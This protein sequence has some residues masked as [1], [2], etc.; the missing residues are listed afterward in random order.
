[1]TLTIHDVE[2]RSPEWYAA[3]CGIVTAS[4]IGRLI[5]V[6][7]LGAIDFDC[8]NCGAAANNPCLSKRTSEP[9]KTLHGERT[10]S[11]AQKTTVIEPA[12]N[13]ESRGLIALL[14]AERISGFVDPTWQSIDMWRGIDDEPLAVD[15]YSRTQ[16][17]VQTC[18]F[19][20]NDEFG[21]TIGY[22]PDGL[23]SSDGLI[24]VKAPRGKG[25][26]L[27]VLGDGIPFEHM[28]QIQCGLLV[29]GRSWCDFISYCG[30]MHMYV[31]R[32]RP[33]ERWRKAIIDAARHAEAA[34]TQNIATYME[35][36]EGFPMT[37]R[38][39]PELEMRVA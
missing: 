27:T 11:A 12:N 18:G 9:I 36:V 6:R 38:R 34:I 25:H 8:P 35:R 21:P 15:L 24:E 14:V 16:E 22:S 19:M 39:E 26:V 13:E 10:P 32:V 30:G 17:P 28:A 7:K 1:M 20:T 4:T 23:V 31:V 2:Q 37:E 3:R 29:S 5:T 33:D